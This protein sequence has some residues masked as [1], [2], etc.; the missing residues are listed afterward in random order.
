MVE[1]VVEEGVERRLV[2]VVSV[3]SG[4]LQHR[5]TRCALKCRHATSCWLGSGQVSDS[6]AGKVQTPIRTA[7]TLRNGC[8]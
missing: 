7:M 4:S 5:C 2:V 3:P 6:D 1:E 8:G